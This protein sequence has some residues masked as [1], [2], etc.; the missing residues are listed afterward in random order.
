MSNR[1]LTTDIIAKEAVMHLENNCVMGGLV[2]RGY[3]EEFSKSVNGYKV[4]STIS[5]RRPAD[6]TVREGAVAAV[7]DVEEGKFSLSV[8]RQRGIDFRFTSE[9]LTLD[10]GDLSDRVIKPAMIQVANRIDRDL[11]GLYVDVPNWVGTPGQTV[12][13]FA[14]FSKAPERLDLMAVPQED[15]HAVLSPTDQWGMLGSQTA[16]YMQKVAEGAYRRGELGEIANVRTYSSQNVQTHTGGT[17]DETTPLTRGTSNTTTWEASK[18]TGTMTLSTD[19]WDNSA[20]IEA[21]MV[22]T[23]ADV[24]DVNPVTKA[25]LPHLKQ[26]V[27]VTAATAAASSSNET[28]L[29]IAP[30]IITSGAHQNVSAAP[31]ND[32]AIVP[33]GAAS[34]GYPQN[35]VFHKNAFALV[36]V[37]M[38]KPQH[39]A[40]LV[41]RRSYKGYNVRLIGYYDGTN[42]V[43]SY[44]LDILYGVKTIDRRLATRLSGT[45]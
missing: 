6:F 9:E 26:F 33:V 8:D 27:V 37:P 12:N 11:L 20:T 19:G 42:D 35:L 7:Q 44:R 2:Y 22:F 5:V 31:G 32:K 39:P 28:Q 25:T 40:E 24:Y 13:S 15:R 18:D 21:G 41:S 1:P 30:A 4:G 43:S 17:R 16:L 10:I 29:T 36:T 34:T 23:I 45:S 14:D 38:A 3:E